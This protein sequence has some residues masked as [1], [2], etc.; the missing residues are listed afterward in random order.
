MN[1]NRIQQIV[2][3]NEWPDAVFSS[4]ALAAAVLAG[5]L[6]YVII[7]KVLLRLVE[8][9]DT[10]ILLTLVRRWRKPAKVLLPLLA[11]LLV[12]PSLQFP[13]KLAAFLQH[14]SGLALIAS[15]AWLLSATI[16]GLQEVILQRYDVTASDNLTARAVSTQVNVLIK[17]AMVLIFIIAGATML[18]TFDKVR[19]VGMSM[20]ASAG[21]AGIIIG[22]AAQRSLAT[23][24]AGIQIAITQPIRLDDVVIVEGEWGRIEE[25]NLTYVVVCIWDL[26]R[27]VLPITYFLEKPFQNWTRV[28]ADLIGTVTLHCDYRVPVEAV[29][30]ELQN[31]LA[32][33]ELWDGKSSGLVVLDATDRTVILRALV[34]SKNAGDAWDLRCHVREKLVEFLQREYPDCLPR[35]RNEL[36][37]LAGSPPLY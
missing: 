12:L 35:V 14:L 37:P 32:G 30:N 5:L 4:L 10:A 34:S 1:G 3:I 7:F 25:I 17:I 31:I 9:Q 21:I 27:L 13:E 8:R 2:N 16:Y 11:L 36:E 33:T 6:A 23:L 22:F 19:Q 29:R 24:I 15:V 20:L 28:S 18:M 26:R